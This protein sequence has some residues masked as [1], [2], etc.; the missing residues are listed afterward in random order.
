MDSFNDSVFISLNG[1]NTKVLILGG[2][3]SALIKAKTLL[4]SRFVVHCISEQ[5][6]DE[7]KLL[8]GA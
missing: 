7:F 5:F 1:M 8:D 6:T 2:G 3:K 4:N